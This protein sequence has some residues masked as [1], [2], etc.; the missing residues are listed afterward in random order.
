MENMRKGTGGRGPACSGNKHYWGCGS[1]EENGRERD[2]REKPKPGILMEIK[3]RE[4]HEK[5]A[6]Y[7]MF[8]QGQG[9]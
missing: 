1:S 4:D 9:E 8:R 3:E 7:E 6:R 5:E 2:D